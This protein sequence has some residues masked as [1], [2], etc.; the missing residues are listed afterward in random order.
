MNG[1]WIWT[2]LLFSLLIKFSFKCTLI[3][4]AKGVCFNWTN[5][6]ERCSICWSL[7]WVAR[8]ERIMEWLCHLSC[9]IDEF[10]QHSRGCRPL[11]RWKIG[12]WG[13]WFELRLKQPQSAVAS[14][15]G[16]Y[17]FIKTHTLSLSLSYDLSIQAVILK[18]LPILPRQ[19]KVYY[20]D[21]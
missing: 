4:S 16:M 15:V 13:K 18:L 1:M 11:G 21:E 20:G 5:Y 2:S 9:D 6:L 10:L 17:S 14:L 19:R 8:I 3:W 12:Q 7:W